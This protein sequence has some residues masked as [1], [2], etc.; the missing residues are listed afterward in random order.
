MR[1]LGV[2]MQ[3]QKQIQTGQATKAAPDQA[4]AVAL[5]PPALGTT[6]TDIVTAFRDKLAG[7]IIR[8]GGHARREQGMCAM[9]AASWLAGEDHSDHPQCTCPVIAQVVRL[10]NDQ[11]IDASRRTYMLQPLIPRLLG[12]NDGSS[13]TRLKRQY[14]ALDEAVRGALPALPTLT[15]K[16][17][18]DI[19]FAGS[20][21]R[22]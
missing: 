11:I 10:V 13:A 12:T 2:I 14:A 16:E 18:A 1:V 4:G 3:K 20:H 21:N 17:A 7:I 8:H 5:A 9:E 22:P 6:L 19:T 15:A